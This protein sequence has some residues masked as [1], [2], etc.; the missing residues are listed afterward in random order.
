MLIYTTTHFVYSYVNQWTAT[1]PT[2]SF[3]NK[4]EVAGTI[5]IIGVDSDTC[6]TSGLTYIL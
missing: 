5:Q 4:N 1:I 3:V 2:N 6:T